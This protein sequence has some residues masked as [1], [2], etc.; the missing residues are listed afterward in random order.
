MVACPALTEDFIVLFSWNQPGKVWTGTLGVDPVALPSFVPEHEALLAIAHALSVPTVFVK[1]EQEGFLAGP[2]GIPLVAHPR[3]GP[4][5]LVVSGRAAAL[6]PVALARVLL[7]DHQLSQR[8]GPSGPHLVTL[9]GVPVI[10]LWEVEVCPGTRILNTFP[11]AA[12]APSQGDQL[13]GGALGGRQRWLWDDELCYPTRARGEGFV[14]LTVL[15]PENV[16]VLAR[17][18][19]AVQRGVEAEDLYVERKGNQ[20]NVVR[21]R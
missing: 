1:L 15:G 18:L 10:P 9:Y 14:A 4:V 19:P 8:A 3:V 20:F 7:E 12:A 13:G 21:K 16:V 6:T 11:A 17:A 2:L 5:I